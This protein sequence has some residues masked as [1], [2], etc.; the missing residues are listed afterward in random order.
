MFGNGGDDSG[1][2]PKQ[3]GFFDEGAR[4]ALDPVGTQTQKAYRIQSQQ[5]AKRC[6]SPEPNTKMGAPTDNWWNHLRTSSLA[7][8]AAGVP[9]NA[10]PAVTQLHRITDRGVAKGHAIANDRMRGVYRDY[11]GRLGAMRPMLYLPRHVTVRTGNETEEVLNPRLHDPE[12]YQTRKRRR[13]PD[14]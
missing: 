1:Q 3:F 9:H 8:A 13:D 6:R 14:T 12:W 7:H 5:H 4:R 2:P 10:N 11:E